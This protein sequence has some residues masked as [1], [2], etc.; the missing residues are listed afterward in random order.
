MG[1]WS[2]SKVIPDCNEKASAAT[3]GKACRFCY[4]KCTREQ[5]EQ[6]TPEAALT[7]QEVKEMSPLDI[8]KRYYRE[9]EG[10]EMDEELCTLMQE[11]ITQVHAKDI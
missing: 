1:V 3:R 5:Q 2:Q 9:A 4:I 11:V 10:E 6:A 8:A 7:I